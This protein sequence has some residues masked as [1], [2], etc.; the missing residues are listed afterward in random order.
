[1]ETLDAQLLLKAA[2]TTTDQGSFTAIAAAYTLD[3]DKERIRPG[4][5]ANTIKAWLARNRPIPLHW[6]HKGDAENVIGSVDPQTMSETDDGLYVEGTLDLEGSDLAKEAWR[7]VKSDTVSLSFGFL[8]EVTPRAK[9]GTREIVNIDLYEVSL[10]PAPANP[11]TRF[12]SLKTVDVV[13]V[14]QA[15][16]LREQ[17]RAVTAELEEATKSLAEANA[18]IDGLKEKADETD[19]QPVAGSVDPLRK[20]L[21]DLELEFA[22]SGLDGLKPPPVEVKEVEVD[23]PS[24]DDLQRHCHDLMLELLSEGLETT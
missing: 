10:T 3:R 5:F 13:S 21:D 15:D 14:E 9:D 6:A 12:L 24:L 16:Q 18:T 23:Q 4:A 19:G 20:Q 22:T 1:M 11:D 8:G 17:L 7:L 2:A